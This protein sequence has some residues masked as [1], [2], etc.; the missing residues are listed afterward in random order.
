M[1]TQK[2][3]PTSAPNS[4]APATSRTRLTD[5]QCRNAVCPQGKLRERFYD[6]GGLYLEVLPSGR[7][8]WY[9]KLRVTEGGKVKEKRM[10]LGG[11]P[12]VK[13]AEA[14][15]KR[16]ESKRLLADG[17]NPIEARRQARLQAAGGVT[18]AEVAEEW[19][20]AKADR[21]SDAYKV[22]VRRLVGN[23][24]LPRLGHRGMDGI[25][26][27]ELKAAVEAILDKSKK[28]RRESA[29]ETLRLA[30]QIW[31]YAIA[32]RGTGDTFTRGNIATP[33]IKA[34]VL[35]PP[36]VEHNKAVTSPE[37]LAALLRVI[38]AYQ[39]Q[40][41]VVPVALQ[42]V[43]LLAPRQGN[44][45]NMRW[46][47]INWQ[48]ATWTVPRPQ[49]K[50]KDREFDFVCPLPRQ[51]IAL[52]EELRPFT[53]NPACGGWVFPG[54]RQRS[55]PLSNNALRSALI[56][57]G[58]K[59]KQDVHGFRTIGRSILAEMGYP[60][61]VIEAQLDHSRREALGDTYDRSQY[62]PQRQEML[63]VWADYLDALAEGR[64]EGDA[65]VPATWKAAHDAQSAPKATS[66]PRK[67]K[68]HHK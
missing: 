33:L 35:P 24:L 1:P 63:Q 21:W 10:G 19:M 49:M 62:L 53:D 32:T 26:P 58:W 44:V 12:T 34:G 29:K 57:C 64:I 42:L 59:G 4:P 54:G 13:L 43:S 9:L 37:E 39:G 31:D 66:T 61:E 36:E 17:K 40:N 50:V 25:A 7:K 67:G 8:G 5:V 65:A 11:Y 52:L 47:Q 48:K 46:E 2:V 18:L 16:D 51:A 28:G 41:R 45:C 60:R 23:F 27:A 38:R 15:D 56:A 55:R 6:E 14:C 30:Q 3:P 22:K 68:V 20:N